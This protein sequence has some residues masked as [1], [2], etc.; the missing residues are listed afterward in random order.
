MKRESHYSF[1]LV[2]NILVTFRFR[3]THNIYSVGYII[4]GSHQLYIEWHLHFYEYNTETMLK[5]VD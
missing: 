5:F 2:T 4:T 3:V 1:S